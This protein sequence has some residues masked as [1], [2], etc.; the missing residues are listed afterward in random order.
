MDRR[1]RDLERRGD[2]ASL[3]RLGQLRC[4][5]ESCLKPGLK[6]VTGFLDQS[7]RAH[8]FVISL[9]DGRQ[10]EVKLKESVLFGLI[11]GGSE[12]EIERFRNDLVHA[13]MQLAKCDRCGDYND[14][15][16]EYLR[17]IHMEMGKLFT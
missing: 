12:N 6:G 15:E 17:G 1:L 11:Y 10:I 14:M 3:K 5:V 9:E 8:V 4:K 16:E 2:P 13:A 7:R